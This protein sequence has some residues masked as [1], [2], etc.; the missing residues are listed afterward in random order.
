MGI[1][2][3]FLQQLRAFCTEAEG[4]PADARGR[5]TR[6][7]LAAGGLFP[8]ASRAAQGARNASVESRG[9]QASSKDPKP[10]KQR[11][12]SRE[13]PEVTTA[14]CW[15]KDWFPGTPPYLS[16]EHLAGNKSDGRSDLASLPLGAAA[17]GAQEPA[18]DTV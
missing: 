1:M 12:E 17:G 18:L 10:P 13:T 8:F 3:L 9:Q 7:I 14:G 2:L 11:Q 5:A 15:T 6:A 4:V 16:P